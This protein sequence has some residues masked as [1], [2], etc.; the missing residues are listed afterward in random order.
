MCSQFGQVQLR[1]QREHFG[2][3]GEYKRQRLQEQRR[4]WAR[5][6]QAAEWQ[7]HGAA[8]GVEVKELVVEHCHHHRDKARAKH[9]MVVESLG[10]DLEVME[11]NERRH[12]HC[13]ML[14]VQQQKL[15]L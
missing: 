15:E 5:K 3:A 2:Q 4:H 12:Q 8:S 7:Q 13:A 11:L 10:Q 14:C 6:V 9:Q 1:R